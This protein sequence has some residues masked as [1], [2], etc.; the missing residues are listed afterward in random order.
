[1]PG[2]YHNK[3]IV[4]RASRHSWERSIRVLPAT[5]ASRGI[6]NSV[7]D[8]MCYWARAQL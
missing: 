6:T 1:V 3:K 4:Q 7:V 2:P 8:A 5:I